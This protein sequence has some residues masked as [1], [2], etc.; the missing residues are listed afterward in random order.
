MEEEP[1]NVCYQSPPVEEEMIFEP[2][3]EES[4][5][6][7]KQKKEHAFHVQF[8]LAVDK[9]SQGKLKQKKLSF[10]SAASPITILP[11]AAALGSAVNHG[12]SD[13]SAQ[14]TPAVVD[15]DKV[16]EDDNEQAKDPS[17]K[18]HK[19]V[20]TNTTVKG[21]IAAHQLYTN[22]DELRVASVDADGKKLKIPSKK[23]RGKPKTVR[24]ASAAEFIANLVKFKIPTGAAWDRKNLTAICNHCGTAVPMTKSAHF[25]SHFGLLKNDVVSA[26]LSNLQRLLKSEIDK[27]EAIARGVSAPLVQAK[28]DGSISTA[29]SVLKKKKRELFSDLVL[30]GAQGNLSPAQVECFFPFLFAQADNILLFRGL[31]ND[32]GSPIDMEYQYRKHLPTLFQ[33]RHT[34]ELRK[35]K[36]SGHIHICN[37]AATDNRKVS[38][39]VTQMQHGLLRNSMQLQIFFPDTTISAPVCKKSL[40]SA[41]GLLGSDGW[42]WVDSAHFDRISYNKK[43]TRELSRD[44]PTTYFLMDRCHCLDA[45]ISIAF[46]SFPLLSRTLTLLKK[47]FKSTR[48]KFLGAFQQYQMSSEGQGPKNHPSPCT[49]R[50]W[51]GEYR[52]AEWLYTEFDI[53][54]RFFHS[55]R[56]VDELSKTASNE[57]DTIYATVA[58]ELQKIF[59]NDEAQLR[60]Q[61]FAVLVVSEPLA[62]SVMQH[63]CRLQPSIHFTWTH[64]QHL[65]KRYVAVSVEH[66]DRQSD[67]FERSM[68]VHRDGL[69]GLYK[70]MQNVDKREFKRCWLALHSN[71][72]KQI[73]KDWGEVSIDWSNNH[74]RREW[75]L[76]WPL[77]A[78]HDEDD[79]EN[80]MVNNVGESFN[81]AAITLF[82]VCSLLDPTAA[83]AFGAPPTLRTI[84]RGII[85]TLDGESKCSEQLYHE[86]AAYVAS[87]VDAATSGQLN[88]VYDIDSLWGAAANGQSGQFVIGATL[89]KFAVRALRVS[90]GSADVERQNSVINSVATKGKAQMG[91]KRVEYLSYLR[92]SYPKRQVALEAR[93]DH[94]L[95]KIKTERSQFGVDDNHLFVVQERSVLRSMRN[96]KRKIKRHPEPE[97]KGQKA[98]RARVAKPVHDV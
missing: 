38:Q 4:P 94:A 82:A 56:V 36:E 77:T 63:Q 47:A 28:L 23:P 46:S 5:S 17:Q 53:L 24:Q 10:G 21:W 64:F 30:A 20:S 27:E 65:C 33:V 39:L 83:A 93:R 34:E 7:K 12:D 43:V 97:Q 73:V 49:T 55:T 72:R 81:E 85:W 44:H 95:K 35:A 6:T 98:K 79:F 57:D 52:Q 25:L 51:T 45:L 50:S 42:S 18:K 75:A 60:T 31:F 29:S 69:L 70:G 48:T 80:P 96:L 74:R 11:G 61:V 87:A 76:K 13:A 41:V 37:D 68:N 84:E 15:L 78:N 86:I 3:D 54:C 26:H 71:M 88:K 19:G 8:A 2:V 40:D 9:A 89:A 16:D 14:A 90:G 58:T 22:K 32:N 59:K 67:E 92:S 62:V 66:L 91:D 1:F